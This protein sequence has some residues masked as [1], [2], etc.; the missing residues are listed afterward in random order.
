MTPILSRIWTIPA[1]ALVMLL[2]EKIETRGDNGRKI[3]VER[4]ETAS[5]YLSVKGSAE[6]GLPRRMV[7]LLINLI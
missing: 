5:L 7:V 6:I 1:P 3:V 2:R 4:P